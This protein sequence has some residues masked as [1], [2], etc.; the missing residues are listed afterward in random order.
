MDALPGPP[1]SYARVPGSLEALA[2][3][4]R[5]RMLMKASSAAVVVRGWGCGWRRGGAGD[6]WAA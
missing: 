2:R 4:I 6:T 3:D 5:L 1:G